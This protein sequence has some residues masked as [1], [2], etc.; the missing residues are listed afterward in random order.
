[1]TDSARQYLRDHTY[2]RHVVDGGLEYLLSGW[3]IVCESVA[4]GEIQYQDDY[5]NDM[6]GRQILAELRPHLDVEQLREADERIARADALI[7]ANLVATTICIWGEEN[8]HKHG[9]VRERDWWYFHRPT[10]VEEGWRDY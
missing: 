9:Y 2:P 3:E 6:D 10:V 4:H 5:L 8:A 1:M 7:R